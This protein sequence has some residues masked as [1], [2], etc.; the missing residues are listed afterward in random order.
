MMYVAFNSYHIDVSDAVSVSRLQTGPMQGILKGLVD[1]LVQATSGQQLSRAYLYG[2]LL[3][4]LQMTSKQAADQFTGKHCVVVYNFD[5]HS[6]LQYYYVK[7]DMTMC[8]DFARR[9]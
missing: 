3:Y 4:Y 7:L 8:G 2:A 9:E 5:T 6:Y 1:G